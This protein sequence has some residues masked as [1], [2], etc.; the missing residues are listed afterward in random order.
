ME[1]LNITL[2]KLWYKL[3]LTNN[4]YSKED[5]TLEEMRQA[6][7]QANALQFIENNEFG[8][9]SNFFISYHM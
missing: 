2:S 1:P 6:A 9:L 5:A 4:R 3:S 7:Q 8:I